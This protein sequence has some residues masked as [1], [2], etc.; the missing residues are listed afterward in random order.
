[1]QPIWVLMSHLKT[2][3]DEPVPDLVCSS[4]K[5]WVRHTYYKHL[6]ALEWDPGY[7]RKTGR[8]IDFGHLCNEGRVFDNRSLDLTLNLL[9]VGMVHWEHPKHWRSFVV[10]HAYTCDCYL[11]PHHLWI[12]P[13]VACPMDQHDW[14]E[15]YFRLW[16]AGWSRSFDWTFRDLV[17][18]K[19]RMRIGQ[20]TDIAGQVRMSC[21][22]RQRTIHKHVGLRV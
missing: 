5:M 2:H 4:L 12:H 19:S 1:M 15:G 6:W 20:H 17:A 10:G 8:A 9:A 18:E 14:Q 22:K 3:Q 21:S 16:V 7:R 13:T 11:P